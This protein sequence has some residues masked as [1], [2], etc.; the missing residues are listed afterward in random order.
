MTLRPITTE[1]LQ[2]VTFPQGMAEPRLDYIAIERLVVDDSYQRPLGPANWKRIQHIAGTFDWAKFSPLI[3]APA[4]DGRLAIIDGQH[5][6]HAALLCGLVS[7]PAML[8]D[9]PPER[10]ATAFVEVNT[11]TIRVTAQAMFK[12][13]LA[14]GAEW[15]VTLDRVVRA[16]GCQMATFAAASRDK[17]PYV[18]Y[19]P[20]LIR[21]AIN[22]GHG[23]CVTAALAALRA[24]DVQ[25]RPALW[26]DFIL[27]PWVTAFCTGLFRA[28]DL[29]PANL[30]AVL[31]RRDPFKVVEAGAGVGGVSVSDGAAT[32]FRAMLRDVLRNG[33]GVAV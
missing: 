1:A 6:A 15:A 9:I 11:V 18:I 17:K 21:K 27:R 16:A 8:V 4:H 19:T 30:A 31:A 7:V 10:Q 26:S 24:Y 22:A 20:Q 28:R 25:G 3:V 32:L 5:R 14:A 2:A 29:T 13:E 12:A 33:R 23:D